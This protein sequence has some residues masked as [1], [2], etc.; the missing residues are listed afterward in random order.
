M[1]RRGSG[2][3]DL[4]PSTGFSTNGV[5]PAADV[6]LTPPPS[7][8]ERLTWH[9]ASGTFLL[10][11]L[12]T[13][14]VRRYER[15]SDRADVFRLAAVLDRNG[16][17]V[18]VGYENATAAA[19]I[20][21]ITDAAGRATTFSIAD[22]GQPVS[23]MVAPD[24]RRATFTYTDVCSS[25]TGVSVCAPMLS[26]T[27]DFLGTVTQFTYDAR[28]YLT[29][30]ET[31]GKTVSIAW[32]P[33]STPAGLQYV[34]SIVDA[35][36]GT[37]RYAFTGGGATEVT[38]PS[39]D[40]ETF[41]HNGNLLTQSIDAW[42]R[43]IVREYQ[44]DGL[45]SRIDDA[46]AITTLAYDGDRNLVALTDPAGRV[47]RWAWDADAYATAITQA[48][49]TSWSFGYDARHNLTSVTSP[50]NHQRRIEYDARGLATARRR[51]ARPAAHDVVRRRRQPLS[52]TDRTNRATTFTHDAVGRLTSVRPG[53]QA[54]GTRYA[55]DANDRLVGVTWPDGSLR[56]FTYD[57]CTPTATTD[58]T[59][60]R[61]TTTWDAAL[62][63]AAVTD[64]ARAALAHDVRRRRPARSRTW[65]HWVVPRASAT[66]RR[67]A[68]SG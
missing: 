8:R 59:G 17:A 23:A 43:R 68:P 35:A 44:A 34:A 9:A 22:A 15:V 36:G 56:V 46:G 27:T 2:S 53:G 14:E 26:T 19:R 63:P 40:V 16:N 12:T 42:G 60:A 38:R 4:F 48:D 61:T 64:A 21:R 24:G 37:T 5:L 1:L 41:L 66:A 3:V 18:Q 11:D 20:A 51:C 30:I 28:G 67:P 49:G 31:A 29:R 58:E 7:R 47:T 45:P 65:T 62:R 25:A 57:A 32:K 6:R 52:D 54:P 10:E 55:Y 50:L 33:P 39:G 13:R